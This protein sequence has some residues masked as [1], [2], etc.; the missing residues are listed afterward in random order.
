MEY[1]TEKIDTDRKAWNSQGKFQKL[2]PMLQRFYA[3]SILVTSF[4]T[5]MS[6]CN[7]ISAYCELLAITCLSGCYSLTLTGTNMMRNVKAFDPFNA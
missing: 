1:Q 6:F 2:K 3:N 4:G 5:M 7:E